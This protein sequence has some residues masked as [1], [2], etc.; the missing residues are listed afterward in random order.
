MPAGAIAMIR[1]GAW[2]VV[3]AALLGGCLSV[4]DGP[5]SMCKTTRDCADGER[6]EEGVCWGNPPPGPFAAVLSSPSTRR[7]LVSRE[8]P[9]VMIGDFGQLKDLTL[10]APAQLTGR[11]TGFC[12]PPMMGCDASTLSSTIT[13]SRR[14]QFA[15]GPGFKTV[16]NADASADSFSV[17]VPRLEAGD[18]PYTVTIVPSSVA[19]PG[20]GRSPAELVPP[21]RLNMVSPTGAPLKVVLGGTNLAKI[22][23]TLTDSFSQGLNQYRVS[24][25]GRWDASEPATE[26]SSA[27]VTDASGAYSITLSAGLVGTVE[28][29]AR[30]AADSV[31][32]TIR[33]ANVDALKSSTHNVAMPA[34]LGNPAQLTVVVTGAG[35][36]GSIKAVA[37]AV[38][39]VTGLVT[40]SVTAFTSS[41]S[42]AIS[43]QQLTKQ[44]GSAVLNLLDGPGMTATYKLSIIPPPSSAF[45]VVFDQSVSFT[46]GAVVNKRLSA[47]FAL[48]GRIVDG[49]GNPLSNVSVTARPSLRFLWTLD[50][51]S[52]A[53][54]ASIPAPNAVTPGGGDFLLYVDAN[55]DQIWGD[56]ELVIEPPA[57]SLVAT[58]I[59]SGLAIP[60]DAA[61]FAT[62]NDPIVVPD[63]AHVHGQI[64]GP[65]GA[66]IDNAELKLFALPADGLSL[67]SEV[68]HAPA[69][70]PV[71]AQLQARNTSDA[72]GV[73]R[74]ALPR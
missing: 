18:Q 59:K 33:V 30:P 41:D 57:Q 56:Y 67:C 55:V 71:P 35:S 12:A 11:V 46:A 25:L 8:I 28:L 23:G 58:Y 45:G 43:D 29:V 26:V 61:V 49:S 5:A 44:D 39:S 3:A 10:K 64:T 54:V 74:L 70:C 15:G 72:N 51:P 19:P 14:A 42:F 63:T 47:R 53:F 48:R 37:G 17:A 38:V 1:S 13:V 7:D 9:Q 62:A 31:A 27:F 68:E 2:C 50:A 6:C 22:T 32:A 52:Q 34:N 73:V 69:S 65:D 4:P 60:R 20:G 16:V 36:D 24:A 21:L 40:P 66:P